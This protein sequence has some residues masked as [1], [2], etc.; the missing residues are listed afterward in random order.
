MIRRRWTGE[1]LRY[2]IAFTLDR[3]PGQC[4]ADLVSWV[5]HSDLDSYGDE[6]WARLRGR[7]PWR[8]RAR[9]GRIPG[10]CVA[11]AIDCG[12]CYCG[13]VRTAETD[14]QMRRGGAKPGVI[15]S[16]EATR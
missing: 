8:P 14:A 5:Q 9:T 1:G 15:V 3:L 2:N 6:W 16:A 11:D 13:K 7:L 12:V 10:S 4:W